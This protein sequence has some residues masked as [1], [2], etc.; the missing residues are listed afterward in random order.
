[1]KLARQQV[2]GGLVLRPMV[3][4]ILLCRAWPALFHK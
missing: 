4:N 2:L 3:L 1:M